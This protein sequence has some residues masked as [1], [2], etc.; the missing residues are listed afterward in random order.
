MKSWTWF[1]I[2]TRNLSR[3]PSLRMKETV[4]HHHP[5]VIKK[6][7]FSL[8]N[9]Q[10]VVKLS[11]FQVTHRELYT[12][13]DRLPVKDG[14]LDRRLVILSSSRRDAPVNNPFRE[15]LRKAHS[16]RPAV[17]VLST[18][19]DITRTSGLLSRFST[20]D[21]SS[22]RYQSFSAYARFT[23]YNITKSPVDPFPLDMCK[24][25]TWRERPTGLPRSF[26]PAQPRELNSPVS[27]KGDKRPC[28]EDSRLSSLRFH[29]RNS[30]ES[31]CSQD[32]PRQVPSQKDR[33]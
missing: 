3:S 4:S 17:S 1:L 23:H 19:L 26:P 29:Q 11:E 25:A 32:H 12:A 22:I 27:H 5:K 8:L 20:L 6:L 21:T 13:A 33:G 7:Q 18:V 24:S 30:K 31:R 10:D 9:P 14:V 28:S 16:V 2:R 15:P